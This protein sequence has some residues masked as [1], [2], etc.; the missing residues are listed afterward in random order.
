MDQA[1]PSS[2][3]RGAGW[4]RWT[5]ACED[6][7]NCLLSSPCIQF[8]MLQPGECYELY[9]RCCSFPTKTLQWFLITPRTDPNLPL[10]LKAQYLASSSDY[11]PV[12][13]CDPAAHLS[14][15]PQ[16]WVFCICS[17]PCLAEFV[18]TSHTCSNVPPQRDCPWWKLAAS[19][20][21]GCFVFTHSTCQFLTRGKIFLLSDGK[22]FIALYNWEKDLTAKLAEV[23]W[24]VSYF[25]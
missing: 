7:L 9:S 21:S 22:L 19:T 17:S 3:V 5:R 14:D 24:D 4:W 2:S 8:F 23:H 1:G 25:T 11:Q 12:T 15:A 18:P 10:L 20:P 13:G 6:D 16:A